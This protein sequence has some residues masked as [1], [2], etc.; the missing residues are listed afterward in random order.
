MISWIQKTFQQH[1]RTIFLVMLAI[2]IISFVFT[3]GASP[4]IGQA[5]RKVAHRAFFDL[6]LGSQEDQERL[7]GDASLSVLLQAGYNALQNDRL[8]QYALQRYAALHLAAELNLPAPTDAEIVAHVQQLR[9]FA[10]QDGKFDAKRYAEFR[11]SLKTNPRLHESDVTRVL[12]D[13]VTYKNVEQLLSGPGYVLPAE[14]KNQLIRVE[15]LW[16]LSAVNV[17]YP[18]FNP[19]I[20]V[21]DAELAKYFEDNAFRYEIAPKIS[22]EYIDF[23]AADFISKVS[24]TDAE[25]RA[26]YDANPAR[27]PKPAADAKAATPALLTP[28]SGPEADFAAVRPQVEA[29]LKQERAQRL[30][31]QTA[32]DLSVALY[33]GKITAGGLNEFLAARKL[34][35]KAVAPFDRTSVPAALGGGAQTGAEAFKLGPQHPFSDVVSTGHGAA[36]LVWKDTLPARKPALAEVKDR[37]VADYREN[38]KR[39]RFVELGRTLHG[40][41]AARLKAGDTLDKAVAAAAGTS[42]AKLEI[43]TWPAFTLATPPA[44]LDYSLYGAI[45]SLQK[46]QLSEMVI[47]GDKGLLVYAADK[48]LPDLNPTGAKFAET[49]AQLAR[50]TASRN[51]SEYLAEIVDR[52]LSKSA[53]SLQP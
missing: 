30:A 11:D 17:D 36:I 32:A 14:V 52:E 29:A 13:D 44:D 24:V 35:L 42:T 49:R 45:E 9:A 51:G 37:V 25:V 41:L 20:A 33:E 15:S 5:G 50:I 47:S 10:G 53:P 46:G 38:E 7:M 19:A 27:F 22:V 26:Y 39:K 40:L 48:K 6:N 43:K 23:P 28:A 16:T 8:Q 21:S 31:E 34:A 12:V 3:I 2:I 18:S 4:G 1:F